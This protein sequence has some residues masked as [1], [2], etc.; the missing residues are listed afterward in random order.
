MSDET[1]PEQL[2]RVQRLAEAINEKKRMEADES[3]SVEDRMRADKK[4]NEALDDV[5]AHKAER[6]PESPASPSTN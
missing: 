1:T 5:R 4:M 3:H 2:D 6:G